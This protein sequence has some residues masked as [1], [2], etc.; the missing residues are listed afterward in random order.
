M[1]PSSSLVVRSFT[2]YK[3]ALR[4]FRVNYRDVMMYLTHDSPGS[5][6]YHDPLGGSSDY[7]SKY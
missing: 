2:F 6:L 3:S 5:L 7:D 1:A 4:C